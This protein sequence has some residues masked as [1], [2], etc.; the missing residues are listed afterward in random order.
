[1]FIRVFY[2]YFQ[3]EEVPGEL[4]QDDLAPDDVMI[5]DVWDQV[6]LPA[7]TMDTGLVPFQCL[8]LLCTP[9]GVCLDRTRIT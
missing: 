6:S 8:H 2:M 5:L 7:V 4:T 1:M 9:A 3:M